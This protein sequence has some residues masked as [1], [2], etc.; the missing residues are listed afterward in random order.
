[1]KYLSPV[2]PEKRE[3][4]EEIYKIP[5]EIMRREKAEW[6]EGRTH[7]QT[8]L[9][10]EWMRMSGQRSLKELQDPGLV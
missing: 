4:Y 5:N 10:G 6:E 8:L 2:S 9:W 7:Q 1:M 3:G